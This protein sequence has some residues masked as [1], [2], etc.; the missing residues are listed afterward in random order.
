MSVALAPMRG[1]PA[2]KH[3]CGSHGLLTADAIARVSGLSVVTIYGRIRRG[4]RGEQLLLSAPKHRPHH[5]IYR[6][7]C[8]GIGAA[9]GIEIACRFARM[10][11]DRAPT[12][13]EVRSSFGMSR[14]TAYRWVAA[15]KAANGVA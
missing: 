12:A 1:K 8:A 13:N 9:G 2:K 3:D 4:V 14:A 10:F 15:W 6:D 5:G 11:R 7:H